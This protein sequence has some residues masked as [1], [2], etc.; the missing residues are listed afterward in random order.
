MSILPTDSEIMGV[1]VAESGRIL[2]TYVIKN[3]LRWKWPHV[4]TPWVLRR[5]KALEKAGKVRRT[6]SSYA[7]MICWAASAEKGQNNG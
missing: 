3:V 2:P 4:R 5:M 7:T 6:A 1:V